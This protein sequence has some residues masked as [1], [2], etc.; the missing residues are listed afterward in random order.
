MQVRS[1]HATSGANQSDD[2]S[3]RH[4]VPALDLERYEG[5]WYEIASFPQ[6]FQEGCVAT[7]ARYTRRDDGRIRVVNECRDGSF[8][9]E[10]SIYSLQDAGAVP[11]PSADG[12]VPPPMRPPKW[13]RRPCGVRWGFGFSYVYSAQLAHEVS[14]PAT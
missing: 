1:R 12:T 8:D 13:L 2:V 9:G 4:N 11:S 10:V 14:Y 6:R 7:S 5:R 3:G